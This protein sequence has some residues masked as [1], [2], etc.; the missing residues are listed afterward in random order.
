[1]FEPLADLVPRHHDYF[2]EETR[3]Q[4]ENIDEIKS[5]LRELEYAC[6]LIAQKLPYIAPPREVKNDIT[7]MRDALRQFIEATEAA[8]YA[9]RSIVA[10]TTRNNQRKELRKFW[11]EYLSDG[12]PE[13]VKFMSDAGL[14][15]ELLT[16]AIER[17]EVRRGPNKNFEAFFMA[18]N[19]LRIFKKHNVKATTYAKGAYFKTLEIIFGELMPDL[20]PE[21]YRGWGEEALKKNRCVP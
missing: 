12:S 14:I 9:A 1:M 13:L 5:F 18:D 15:E 7:A 17:I 3:A 4:L 10:T 19:A 21:A 11:A 16:E 20:G 6:I 2:S 8:T